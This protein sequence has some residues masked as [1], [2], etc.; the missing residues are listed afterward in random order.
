[1]SERLE[2]LI[3][4]SIVAH[5]DEPCIWWDGVW[6]NGADFLRLVD[7]CEQKLKDAGFSRG[8]RLV[9]MMRISCNGCCSLSY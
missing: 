6:R 4:T 9:V 3:G 8:Q 7:D 2:Q 1:M 5:K